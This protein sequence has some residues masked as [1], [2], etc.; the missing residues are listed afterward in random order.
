MFA[1][2]EAEGQVQGV[3]RVAPQPILGAAHAYV[4]DVRSHFPGSFALFVDM[5]VRSYAAEIAYTL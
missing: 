5:A 4:P 2:G 1:A 3:P